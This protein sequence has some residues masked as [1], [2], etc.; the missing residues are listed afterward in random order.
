MITPFG[1]P[2]L[3]DGF[4]EVDNPD[5]LCVTRDASFPFSGAHLLENTVKMSKAG[6]EEM[7]LNSGSWV[8]SPPGS[9]VVMARVS[10]QGRMERD[11]NIQDG[12]KFVVTVDERS[13]SVWDAPV[14]RSTSLSLTKPG[15]QFHSSTWPFEHLIRLT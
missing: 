15:G 13:C 11:K 8:S 10:S 14:R 1:G 7:P 5:N 6:A 3:E 12:Q 9:I 4:D 2:A